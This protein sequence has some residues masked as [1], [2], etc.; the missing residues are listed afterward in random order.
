MESATLPKLKRAMELKEEHD[1]LKITIETATRYLKKKIP[2]AFH[3]FT[4]DHN[5]F[6]M[7]CITRNKEFNRKMLKQML[8]HAEAR[9]K[10][11]EKE[12]DNL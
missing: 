8:E 7:K 9:F 1:E 6:N 11:V 5:P 4:D 3:V 10:E 2:F 12:I